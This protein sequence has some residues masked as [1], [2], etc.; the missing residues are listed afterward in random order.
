MNDVFTK[1]HV[2]LKKL[3]KCAP[4]T[5]QY[6]HVNSLFSDFKFDLTTGSRKIKL[7]KIF[8]SLHTRRSKPSIFKAYLQKTHPQQL[9]KQDLEPT[10][11]S[12][13]IVD[14]PHSRLYSGDLCSICCF[15]RRKERQLF[16]LLPTRSFS[17]QTRPHPVAS[18]EG[19]NQ[20]F[21]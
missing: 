10:K 19:E 8:R 2:K 6:V 11:E 9:M 3:R 17:L 12:A 15:R 16:L 20:H 4:R 5:L 1:L 18:R 21:L 7:S 13:Y 14:A